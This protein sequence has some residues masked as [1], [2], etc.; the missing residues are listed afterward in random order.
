[1]EITENKYHI[2]IKGDWNDGDFV[3]TM[4]DVNEEEKNR[5]INMYK[6]TQKFIRNYEKHYGKCWDLWQIQNFLDDLI[7]YTEEG[8]EFTEY[9][10]NDK[11]ISD[12]Y[13]VQ[14]VSD[15]LCF[16]EDYVP[17]GYECGIHTLHELEVYEFIKKERY[18]KGTIC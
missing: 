17:S 10:K 18:D 12:L 16:F 13:T 1:M 2:V 4:L 11:W 9:I 7:L 15:I 6:L 5:I 8:K 3:Y 14:Q